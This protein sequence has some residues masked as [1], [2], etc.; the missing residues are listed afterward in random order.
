MEGGRWVASA[1]VLAVEG[2]WAGASAD[3][4]AVEGGWGPRAAPAAPTCRG[5]GA[6]LLHDRTVG[7]GLPEVGW[8][9]KVGRAAL[10]RGGTLQSVS[11]G[12]PGGGRWEGPAASA[13]SR[14]TCDGPKWTSQSTHLYL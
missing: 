5:H 2:G 11:R 7:R 13:Q 9:W 4:L 3:V 10:Q 12:V 1:D 14:E 8:R 6:A